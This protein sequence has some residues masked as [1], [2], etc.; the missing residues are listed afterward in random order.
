MEEEGVTLD[1][2]LATLDE[3]RERYYRAITAGSAIP[4]GAK[5]R[6]VSV[7][8]DDNSVTVTEA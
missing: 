3:D 6:V 8:D 4:T 1:E 7:N 2:I 5:V